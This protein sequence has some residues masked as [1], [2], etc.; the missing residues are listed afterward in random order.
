MGSERLDGRLAEIHVPT[1]VV[2]GKQDEL[3]PIS[4]GERYAAGIAGARLVSFEKC[5]HVPPVE[6]VPEF[7]SAVTSFL[8]GGVTPAH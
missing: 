3:L 1:L 6:K 5:G 8:D 7:L 2:W 4:S